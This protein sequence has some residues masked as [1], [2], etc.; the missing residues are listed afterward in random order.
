MSSSSFKSC[1]L[2]L[3]FNVLEQCVQIV[4]ISGG[5]YLNLHLRSCAIAPITSYLIAD[6]KYLLSLLQCLLL[7]P[8]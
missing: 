7:S 3:F 8:A 6:L 4:I 2:W 1:K 5:Y